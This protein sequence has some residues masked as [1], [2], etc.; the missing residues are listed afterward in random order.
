MLARGL[1]GSGQGGGMKQRIGRSIIRALA[2]GLCA[3][4]V[5]LATQTAPASAVEPRVALVIGNSSYELAPLVNPANDARAMAEVLR[6]MGFQV[7]EARDATKSQMEQALAS[8]REALAG[9]QGVGLLYY[10]GHGLQLDW[11][12]YLLPV[13]ARPRNA[14][15]V[16]RDALDV[17]QVLDAFRA[18][19]TR[20]NIVVLDACRDNPFGSSA[21][22]KGLAQMDAPPGTLLAYATAPGSLAEDGSAAV[23]NGL[24]TGYLVKEMRRPHARIEEVF[25]RVRLQVRQH[26][27]GRQVPWESTSLEDDFIFGDA[28]PAL[29]AEQAFLQQ[30][31]AWDRIKKSRDVRDFYAF[32]RAYPS[33]AMAELAQARLDQ[34]DRQ[35]LA[36]APGPEG[37]GGAPAT[38]RFRAG[39]QYEMV[40][41]DG[42]TQRERF[43]STVRITQVTDE[44]AEY[45]GIFGSGTRG[46]ATLAGA[47]VSDSLNAYDPPLVMIPGGEFQVGRRWAG[48]SKRTDSSGR[49]GWVDY[50][51]RVAARETVQVEGGTFQ[52]YRVEVEMQFDSGLRIHTTSWLQPDWGLPVKFRVERRTSATGAP[53]VTVREMVSRSRG[54]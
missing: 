1:S 9:R 8:T 12:N 16:R 15:D 25:K 46:S 50:T 5:A 52:V 51:S 28:V 27:Q 6:D 43:R 26:S 24:Y 21:S 53:D 23:G 29:S 41:K 22:G 13:D 14:S 39:D 48:R 4:G 3:V 37:V 31:S 40:F 20:M 18:A 38:G 47:V 10:A 45:S 30:K 32:L 33:G 19:G 49:S 44:V 17:Q 54:S 42:Y 36:P 11:R 34:L 7:L 2:S 35:V